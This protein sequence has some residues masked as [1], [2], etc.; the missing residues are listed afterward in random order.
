MFFFNLEQTYYPRA[1]LSVIP[2]Y[3]GP[4]MIDTPAADSALFFS[5][6]FPAEPVMIAPACPILLPGGA[7][8]PTINAATGF[9]T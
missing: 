5:S 8:C 2:M 9:V 4:G 1:S 3:A 7:L 6:A